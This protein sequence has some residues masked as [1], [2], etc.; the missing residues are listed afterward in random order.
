MKRVELKDARIYNAP[1]HFNFVSYKL[2]DRETT[3]TKAFWV[4]LS[5]YLPGG[6]AEMD[7]SDSEKVY[8]VTSGKVKVKS[9]AGEEFELSET[10]SLY[11]A[12]GE[13]RFV[14]NETRQP[15]TILVIASY[16]TGN[17]K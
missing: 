4:A 16:P 7:S 10:D 13:K 17:D 8:L 15:A 12:P 14:I 11:V 9:E 1:K 3:G 2:H 6:G 5:H